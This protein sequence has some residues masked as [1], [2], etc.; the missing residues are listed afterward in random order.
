LHEKLNCLTINQKQILFILELSLNNSK[1]HRI[2]FRRSIK[3]PL[4]MI[5]VFTATFTFQ[6]G[7]TFKTS[8]AAFAPPCARFATNT[9]Y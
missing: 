3:Q 5:I 6:N 9:M 7:S 8:I 2:K 4:S 1:I